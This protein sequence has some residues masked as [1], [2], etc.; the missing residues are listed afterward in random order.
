MP[1]L[2]AKLKFAHVVALNSSPDTLSKNTALGNVAEG[3]ATQENTKGA[4]MAMF[5]NR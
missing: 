4:K 3:Q 2:K 1:P 5:L